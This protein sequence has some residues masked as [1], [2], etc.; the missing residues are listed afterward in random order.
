[1]A[2]HDDNTYDLQDIFSGKVHHKV[3]VSRIKQG[4]IDPVIYMATES[5]ETVLKICD[6]IHENAQ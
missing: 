3:H 1:M 4:K 6:T 5:P 2:V